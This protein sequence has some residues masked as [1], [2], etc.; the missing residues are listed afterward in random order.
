MASR[1]SRYRRYSKKQRRKAFLLAKKI[2]I[3]PASKKLN[4][5]RSTIRYWLSS[6]DR[7]SNHKRGAKRMFSVLQEN[8]LLSFVK[9]KRNKGESIHEIDLIEKVVVCRN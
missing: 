8:E 4:I 2:G 3:S 5:P 6:A 9:C 7:I 1:R